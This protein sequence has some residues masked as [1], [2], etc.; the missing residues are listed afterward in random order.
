[1]ARIAL[2]GIALLG[3]WQSLAANWTGCLL[4][5]GKSLVLDTGTAKLTVTGAES[6]YVG[7]RVRIAGK[8]TAAGIQAITITKLPGACL[9][10]IQPAGLFGTWIHSREEDRPGARV[11]RLGGYPLPPARGRDSFTIAADGTFSE[12]SIGRADGR[13]V[14]EGTWKQI[15]P[16]EFQASTGGRPGRLLKV[17]SFAKDKLEIYEA[18]T[19]PKAGPAR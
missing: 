12:S 17:L 2:L 14:R 18:A 1:M 16:S 5:S 19:D 4:R 11:Y 10:S 6:S 13:D 15:G 7:N 8:Q 9:P 3:P